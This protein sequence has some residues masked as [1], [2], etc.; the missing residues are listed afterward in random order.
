MAH[1]RHP[2]LRPAPAPARRLSAMRQAWV[3]AEELGVDCL[4]N[5]DHFYPALRRARRQA[6]RGADRA[7]RDGR[8]DRARR[9][10]LARHLQRLPQPR[11]LADAHRTIDHISGGRA[12]LGIGA[13]WFEKDYDEYGY[14]FGDGRQPPARA[15]GGAAADRAP[16]GQA[17]PAAASRPA[18]DPDR[19]RRRRSSRCKLVAAARRHLALVRRRRRRAREKHEILRRALRG[20]RPR[21]GRD[22][23]H[24]GRARTASGTSCSTPASRTSSSASA[25]TAPA[26]TSAACASSCSGGTRG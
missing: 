19:R 6:L 7:R 8:G 1:V 11:L 5:W 16:P 3:E 17:Q 10:R 18:P 14:E 21:P 23:A 4:F 2:C 15:G 9:D 26:T 12:I 20:R 24:L 13:G 25:A 22:R